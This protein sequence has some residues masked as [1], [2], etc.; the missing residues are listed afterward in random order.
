M[1]VERNGSS[2][3][4]VCDECDEELCIDDANFSDAWDEAK[5]DGWHAAKDVDGIWTHTC[6]MCSE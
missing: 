3:T 6:D 4:F 5:E 1:T 2:I